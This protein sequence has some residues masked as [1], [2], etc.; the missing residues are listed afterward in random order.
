MNSNLTPKSLSDLAISVTSLLPLTVS[1]LAS[2]A[3]SPSRRISPYSMDRIYSNNNSFLKV[4]A[5][6]GAL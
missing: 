3:S 1:G 6:T 5:K 4:P 2:R